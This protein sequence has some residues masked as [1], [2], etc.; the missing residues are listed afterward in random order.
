MR[1]KTLFLR[2]K[3]GTNGGGVHRRRKALFAAGFFCGRRTGGRGGFADDEFRFNLNE[4]RDRFV[5]EFFEQ[6]LSG[7]SAHLLKRLADGC[8]RGDL[9]GGGLDIVEA[10]HGDVFRNPEASFMEGTDGSHCG[11]VVEAKDGG[12]GASAG[13]ELADTGVTDLRRVRV[14]G[15]ID[16]EVFVN[17]D[18]ELQGVAK[19][20]I[21]A[22]VGVG[23]E[24]LAV[25]EGDLVMA[26]VTKVLEGEKGGSFFIE[27]DVGDSGKRGVASDRDCGERR[28]GVEMCVDGEDTVDAA[29]AEK[30]GVGFDEILAVTMVDGEIEVVL[31][32]EQVSDAGEYLRV[33]AFAELGQKD[34]DRLHA[35]ALERSGDHGGLIVELF[36]GGPDASAG[37]FWDGAAGRIVQDEGDG[38]GTEAEMFGQRFEAN[39]AWSSWRGRWLLHEKVSV[40]RQRG[41]AVKLTVAA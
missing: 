24:G 11:D 5:G 29:G 41:L 20:G 15:E 31:T 9:E 13:D 16:H 32:H 21:P 17:L 18:A 37:G 4:F 23:A 26:E 19:S 10:D 8:E 6:E 36:C 2:P 14:L 7:G 35:L 1:L 3:T 27:E 25:H 38:G 30:R 39:V 40:C 34:P 28:R 12:E 33:V 22:G